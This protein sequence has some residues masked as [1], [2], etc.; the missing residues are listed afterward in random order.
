MVPGAAGGGASPTPVHTDKDQVT[1]NVVIY[2][3]EM[4]KLRKVLD[5]H[6]ARGSRLTL[7]QAIRYA[8]LQADFEGLPDVP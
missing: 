7:S 2:R 5:A 8:I 6:E 3:R 4:E 1:I